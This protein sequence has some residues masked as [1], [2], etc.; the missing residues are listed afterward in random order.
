MAWPEAPLIRLSI[1]E[2]TTTLSLTNAGKRWQWL[3]PQTSFTRRGGLADLNERLALD[4]ILRR[5]AGAGR[6][7]LRSSRPAVD[8][9][10]HPAIERPGMGLEEDLH[11]GCPLLRRR[12][13]RSPACA[14]G[15][16]SR[17]GRDSRS[18]SGSGTSAMGFC[19]PGDAGDGVDD[20]R[21]RLHEALLQQGG[22]G[23]Q[24]PGGETA[25]VGDQPGFLILARNSSGRP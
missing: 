16:R 13:A 20:D 22:K 3:V 12:S 21:V 1:T 2:K 17:R 25:G 10:K 6:W 11:R 14:G 9:G 23:E 5:A 4:R 15:C 24:R 7:P 19:R 18:C 8:G